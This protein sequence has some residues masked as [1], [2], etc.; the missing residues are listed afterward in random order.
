MKENR[1]WCDHVN[2]WFF[3]VKQISRKNSTAKK[4]VNHAETE[5]K[6]IIKIHGNVSRICVF[7]K[8]LF[9]TENNQK[10]S[11]RKWKKKI[12]YFLRHRKHFVNKLV[13]Y[14]SWC[15]LSCWFGIFRRI[16]LHI[17]S[18]NKISK[19]IKSEQQIS[20]KNISI[21]KA[22]RKMLGSLQR[23]NYIS[24]RSLRQALR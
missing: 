9:A 6:K 1:L 15:R 21:L 13:N 5:K 24:I 20:F 18:V 14:F 16:L 11:T 8:I 4:I 3:G 7:K 10:I 23:F 19:V 22:V 17:Q 2:W 12:K